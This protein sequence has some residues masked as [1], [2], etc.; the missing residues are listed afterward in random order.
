MKILEEKI[1]VVKGK[2]GINDN[3]FRIGDESIMFDVMRNR[4]Y[5]NPLRVICQEPMSNARD[6]HREKGHNEPIHIYLPENLSPYYKIQ[7]FGPGINPDRMINV[8]IAFGCSTKRNDN[9]Q[10]GGFGLG[11]KC[12][13]AYSDTFSIVTI[14]DEMGY[15]IKRTYTAYI[16][17]SRKGIISL[18]SQEDTEERTG[19]TIIIPAKNK[20]FYNFA[21]WTKKTAM[22]WDVKPIIHGGKINWEVLPKEIEGDNWFITAQ[23]NLSTFTVTVDDIPY[24]LNWEA[25]QGEINKTKDSGKINSLYS[26]L[27]NLGKVAVLNYKNGEVMLSASREELDYKEFT[28]NAIIKKLKEISEEYVKKTVE[29]IEKKNTLLDANLYWTGLHP[30]IKTII[31]TAYWHGIELHE[32][33]TLPNCSDSF[34]RVYHKDK[35]R[36]NMKMTKASSKHIHFW[37]N[38]LLILNDLD[39]KDRSERRRIKR[40]FKD[41]QNINYVYVLC[42]PTEGKL[43]YLKDEYESL[44]IHN[45]KPDKIH[46][47]KLVNPNGVSIDFEKKYTRENELEI[48]DYTIYLKELSISNLSSYKKEDVVRIGGTARN[49]N[50]SYYRYDLKEDIWIP[51]YDV[52]DFQNGTGV[53]VPISYRNAVPYSGD[54]RAISKHTLEIYSDIF[55]N[56]YHLYGIPE[57][58]VKKLGKGWNTIFSVIESKIKEYIESVNGVCEKYGKCFE[59]ATFEKAFYWLSYLENDT[60]LDKLDKDGIAYKYIIISREAIEA[61]RDIKGIGITEERCR[62]IINSNYFHIKVEDIKNKDSIIEKHRQIFYDSYPLITV[63]ACYPNDA[64]VVDY[65]NMV[66]EKK[67]AKNLLKPEN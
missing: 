9:I 11:A 1:E 26:L 22:F 44:P 20:D 67:K 57:K 29:L 43:A 21:E 33:Y 12:P 7:D 24:S 47:V 59:K 39:E 6:A 3:Y 56:C 61:I 35:Y 31:G 48:L 19:T 28:I 40:L 2:E 27:R 36:V 58:Q 46:R 63:D 65:I 66:D 25:I 52:I 49:P 45:G 32:E 37:V 14:T 53:Y 18:L 30:N 50:A 17:E 60:I 62:E 8:F 13:F 64:H 54:G 10:T 34:F 15:N 5:S 42:I 41:N 51:K 55:G 4:L 16:D 38:S 23:S